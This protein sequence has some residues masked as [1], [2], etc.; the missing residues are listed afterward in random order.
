MDAVV[1]KPPGSDVVIGA[2]VKLYRFLALCFA[3]PDETTL[4]WWKGP[5]AVDEI[6]SVLADLDSDGRLVPRVAP[7]LRE[8]SRDIGALSLD[9]LESTYIQMF[10]CSI[11]QV[12]CPPY[13]SLYTSAN[14]DKRLA[15]MAAVMEFYESCGMQLSGDFKD[16]PDHISVEFEFLH[17]LAYEEARAGADGEDRLAGFFA[18]RA[19]DFVDRHVLGLIDGMAAVA[20]T[21][22]PP[23]VFFRLINVA[24]EIVRYDRENRRTSAGGNASLQKGQDR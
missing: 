22:E 13:S 11:P 18:D 9:E 23:N 3:H 15:E 19:A 4:A 7:R 12:L 8:F 14:D 21:I 10:V 5:A 2:R 16:L 24:A 6:L 20:A 1:A 17:Y